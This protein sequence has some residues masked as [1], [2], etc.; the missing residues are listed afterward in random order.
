MATL[1]DL[2][3]HVPGASA[4][5]SGTYDLLTHRVDLHGTAKL[6]E[7]LSKTATG[8]KSFL[9]KARPIFSQAQT[10][11]RGP[12]SHYRSLWAH[13]YRFGA[14]AGDTRKAHCEA[15]AVSPCKRARYTGSTQAPDGLSPRASIRGRHRFGRPELLAAQPLELGLDNVLA[16]LACFRGCRSRLQRSHGVIEIDGIPPSFTATLN[17]QIP[18]YIHHD[19]PLAPPE[20]QPG[21]QD[22]G[23][24]VM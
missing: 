7:K 21:F 23:A 24:L 9:L 19:D 20:Q 14:V 3:F 15:R 13:V 2:R 5:L 17:L 6:D 1:S 4:V 11:F 18:G 16:A 8:I 12:D 22:L 10:S